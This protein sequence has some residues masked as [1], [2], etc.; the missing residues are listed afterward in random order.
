MLRNPKEP[1]VP[2]IGLNKNLINLLVQS[3]SVTA[4]L[5]HLQL[6]TSLLRRSNTNRL[7]SQSTEPGCGLSQ[8]VRL[9]Q[10]LLILILKIEKSKK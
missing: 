5:C 10:G 1:K 8:A 9:D 7:P 2:K 4:G 3:L 6:Q